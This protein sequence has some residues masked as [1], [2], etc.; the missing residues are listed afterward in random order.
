M[1]YCH[2]KFHVPTSHTIFIIYHHQID[3]RVQTPRGLHVAVLYFTNNVVG[4]RVMF[5]Y[6]IMTQNMKN[7][8]S[9]ARA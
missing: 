4:T 9:V 3:N 2:T 8:S 7:V 6:N 1:Y 5:L